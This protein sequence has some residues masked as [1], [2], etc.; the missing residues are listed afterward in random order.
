[1]SPGCRRTSASSNSVAALCSS[2]TASAIP[3]G[4]RGLVC[5]L[6]Y[7]SSPATPPRAPFEGDEVRRVPISTRFRRVD[8]GLSYRPYCTPERVS[9]G[10][11]LDGGGVYV[12]A[13]NRVRLGCSCRGAGGRRRYRR[14]G[15]HF[16]KSD[17]A[18]HNARYADRASERPE[19]ERRFADVSAPAA[20][21]SWAFVS[22]M[23]TSEVTAAVAAAPI[24]F[25][26][27]SNALARL[28]SAATAMASDMPVAASM[29][30]SAPVE[31][32]PAGTVAATWT[33]AA[34]WA[35]VIP[36]LWPAADEY[37]SRNPHATGGRRHPPP[38]RA[39]STEPYSRMSKRPDS[40]DSKMRN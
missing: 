17:R 14:R 4:V 32:G 5:E 35:T 16:G 37:G 30:E 20:L 31:I 33:L 13:R 23:A 8:I 10:T 40:A 7:D 21:S 26:R 18:Q 24:V 19:G 29:I 34:P 9:G 3:R 36:S 12:G 11:G 2:P 6:K 25:V 27:A 15:L 1:M 38:P 22:S 39:H 28:F